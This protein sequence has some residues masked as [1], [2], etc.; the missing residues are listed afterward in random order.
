MDVKGK[1]AIIPPK[2]GNR[3]LTVEIIA[4]SNAEI[5][6]LIINCVICPP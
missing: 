5:T 4:I 2:P 3:L 6:V 1:E